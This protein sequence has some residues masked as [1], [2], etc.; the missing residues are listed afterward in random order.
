MLRALLIIV[1]LFCSFMN[2]AEIL[3]GDRD[4]NG[5]RP[6]NPSVGDFLLP[7][8]K[9]DMSS[10]EESQF[11]GVLDVTGYSVSL[12]PETGE[13]VFASSGALPDVDEAVMGITAAFGDLILVGQFDQA[14]C[15]GDNGVG[16]WD[17][18]DWNYVGGGVTATNFG[19]NAAILYGGYLIIGGD[20][21]GVGFWP[22]TPASCIAR[23]NGSAWSAL[24]SGLSGGGPYT[25][26]SAFA[27]HNG[28]L[29]VGGN[30]TTAGGVAA[31]A[32]ARWNG[33]SWSSLGSGMGSMM[34]PQVFALGTYGSDLIAGGSFTTAGGVTV[35]G[36]ARWN[37]SAWLAMSS[38]MNSTVMAVAEY[39]S[40]L[41]AGGYFTAAGGVSVNYI[42]RWNGTAWNSFGS[43]VSGGNP[44]TS[45]NALYVLGTE[46]IVGGN[47]ATAGA[48]SVNHIARWN[49]GSWMS[50]GAGV[51]GGTGMTQV[52]AIY[53]WGGDL[54]VG[55]SFTV[56]GM[57]PASNI[58]AWD[59]F[60]WSRVGYVC[61]D[62]DGSG[63]IDIDDIVFLINYVFNPPSPAPV[64]FSMGDADCSTGIDIDDI[65]YLIQYVFAGGPS[66]GDSC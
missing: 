49:G 18:T 28:Q 43:G 26:V 50:L 62:A 41:Y 34:I 54:I 25:T 9:I 38:G 15:L 33:S 57:N 35:N 61:G 22:G 2:P 3:C 11:E 13:P 27:V 44:L 24:G 48:V 53:S 29:I 30:F 56:A 36:I 31:S 7:N 47:F 60:S 20:F 16:G 12:D 1:V 4:A 19:V 17:G 6:E 66:P 51:F 21:T 14:G 32:I 37:G 5:V 42:A 39:N 23:W 52:N 46:L 8:G 63:N 64:P 10:V 45:V 59:G 65:V 58:A 55:G 40:E